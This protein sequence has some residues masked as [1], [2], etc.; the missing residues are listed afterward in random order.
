MRTA[1]LLLVLGT[2]AAA[3]AAP[4]PAPVLVEDV[5]AT[6]NGRAIMLSD[7]R[8]EAGSSVAYLRRTNPAALSDPAVMRKLRESALEELITRELLVQEAKRDGLTASDHDLDDAVEEIKSRFKEDPDTGR[9]V[10]DARAEK[11]F[12]A[13]LKADGVDYGRYR[14]SLTDDILARKVIALDAGKNVVPASDGE[15]RAYFGRIQDYLA[16]KSTGVPAGMDAE[17]GAALRKAA[18]EVRTL[19]S[20]AVRVERILIRVSA[21]ADEKELARA[22]K[23]SLALKRRLDE[24]ADFEKLAR[25]ESEDSES[26]AAGGDIGFIARGEVPAAVEKEIFS[27]PVGRAGGPI[28]T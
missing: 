27:L 2:R 14:Q 6:V 24:G 11:A 28:L 7:Y 26:A 1:L 15:L 22:R 23:A 3:S 16:S 12:D 10:G 25:S 18:L 8:K 13:K 19:S 20:E 9:E 5:V 21:P 4:A 17:D